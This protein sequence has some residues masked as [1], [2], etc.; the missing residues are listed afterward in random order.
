MLALMAQLFHPFPGPSAPGGRSFWV[1]G[2]PKL[3]ACGEEEEEEDGEEGSQM[4]KQGRSGF[5]RGFVCSAFRRNPAR[6]S[7]GRGRNAG[8]YLSRRTLQRT[9]R[10]WEPF[11][12]TELAPQSC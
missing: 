7:K 9:T 4:W 11:E 12:T 2:E 5:S 1:S 6:E 3:W 10:I 8:I